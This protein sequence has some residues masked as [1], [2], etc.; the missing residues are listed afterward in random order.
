[1]IRIENIHDMARGE[2][3]KRFLIAREWPKEIVRDIPHREKS[4]QAHTPLAPIN[5]LPELAPSEALWKWFRHDP[6]K[7]GPFRVR[8]FREL[9]KKKRRQIL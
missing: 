7:S 3:M 8:Y 4:G 2:N 6:E 9:E 5:W 1:M